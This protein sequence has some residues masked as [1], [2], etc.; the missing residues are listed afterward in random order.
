ML[1]FHFF[2]LSFLTQKYV[3]FV[4]FVNL[5][6]LLL[7]LSVSLFYKGKRVRY[8]VQVDGPEI[9]SRPKEGLSPPLGA[10][11]LVQEEEN[12]RVTHKNGSATQ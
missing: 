4:S 2:L 6:F 10:F 5:Q 11:Y 7:V 1:S 3:L 8:N 9:F 12:S